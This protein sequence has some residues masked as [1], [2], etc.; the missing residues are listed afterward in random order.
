M[1]PKSTIIIIVAIVLCSNISLARSISAWTPIYEGVWTATGSDTYPR[2]MAAYAIR[3][4]M[5]NP[6]VSMYATP[7]NGSAPLETTLQTPPSFLSAY[8]LKAAVNANFFSPSGSYADNWGLVIS[9]GSIVSNAQTDVFSTQLLFTSS[10]IASMIVRGTNPSG[11]YNAVGGAEYIL[12]YGVNCGQNLDVQPRTVMGLSKDNRFLIMLVIDGR[13]P[14]YSEGCNHSEAAGWLIDFGAYNGCI[15]D[16]GGSSC[17]CTASDGVLNSPSDG[18]PRA[19]GANL[20][21]DSSTYDPRMDMWGIGQ[22]DSTVKQRHWI[23]SAGSWTAW[24]SYGAPACGIDVNNGVT[25]VARG[26]KLLDLFVVG[27]DAHVYRKYYNGYNW[28]DWSSIAYFPTGVSCNSGLDACSWGIDRIDLVFVGSNGKLYQK[29]WDGSSWCNWI[30]LGGT[31]DPDQKPTIASWARGRLDIF[32]AD[33]DGEGIMHKAY[34]GSWSGW[35][36]R[37]GNSGYGLDAVSASYGKVHV[38]YTSGG[39]NVYRRA[40]D[41]GNWS[42]S[43]NLGGGFSSAPGATSYQ[44]GHLIVYCYDASNGVYYK[45]YKN[46]IWY[47]W[48]NLSGTIYHAP[49]GC[50]WSNDTGTHF[51]NDE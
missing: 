16:G 13:Q 34:S 39:G 10:H 51:P 3:V 44:R 45:Q 8:G 25:T 22:S 18:S 9:S 41:Y 30:D 19:V 37:L 31:L 28:S 14:G 7:S 46:D 50:S 6:N 29:Y 4:D 38:F 35:I 24:A 49:D 47:N 32:A 42:D 17:I 15:F 27:N 11:I 21:A 43:T 12:Q 20:G 40:Y 36:E 2:P 23:A 1:R 48:N 5:A 26:P 33:D